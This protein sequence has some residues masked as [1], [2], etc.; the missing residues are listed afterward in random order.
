MRALIFAVFAALLLTSGA[1]AQCAFAPTDSAWQGA[2]QAT[3]RTLCLQRELSQST[4][5]L[6]ERMRWRIELGT[7]VARN[8]L[9]LL[10]QRAAIM[11]RN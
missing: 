11:L 4:Q 5:A 7:Q 1:Q 2:E 10:Q 9:L 6:A 3:A 8:E